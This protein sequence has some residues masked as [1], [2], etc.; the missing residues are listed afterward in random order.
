M[1]Y[2]LNNNSNYVMDSVLENNHLS[3][4]MKKKYLDMLR[5]KI[6]MIC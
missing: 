4:R 2:V 5:F 3:L 1:I 6:K